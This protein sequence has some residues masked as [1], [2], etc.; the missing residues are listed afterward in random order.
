MGRI[1]FQFVAT[2]M[3]I[4]TSLVLKKCKNRTQPLEWPI[5]SL[6]II[7]HKDMHPESLEALLVRGLFKHMMPSVHYANSIKTTIGDA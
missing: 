7:E 2:C 5:F 6:P 1:G 4:S 3:A